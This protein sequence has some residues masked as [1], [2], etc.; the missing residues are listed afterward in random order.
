MV[1]IDEIY[2]SLLLLLHVAVKNVISQSDDTSRWD[3]KLK[4]L[5]IAFW[6]H[7]LKQTFT[8]CDEF[9]HFT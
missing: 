1:R 9:Y 6:F 4:V 3:F 7:H 2:V 5:N 8:L